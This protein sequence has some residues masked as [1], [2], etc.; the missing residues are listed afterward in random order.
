M[1]YARPIST[2]WP[3]ISTISSTYSV[4]WGTSVGRATP[5]L[6]IASNHTASHLVVISC[7]GR[8][9]RLARLMMLSSMSVMLL[10]R[11]TFR[12]LHSR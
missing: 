4:A 11:R 1:V 5:S 8:F 6:P 10:T 7:H 3:I 9:S 2:S 12:P